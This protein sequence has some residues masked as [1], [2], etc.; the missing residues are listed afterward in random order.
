[1]IV[2]PLKTQKVTPNSIPIEGLLDSA[3]QSLEQE[4]IVVISAKI[5]ALCEGHVYEM[6]G[7]EKEQLVAAEADYYLPSSY[8]QYGFCISVKNNTL[9][10]SAG[11]DESNGNGFFVP[12]PKNPQESANTI[13][14]YLCEKFKIKNL[15]IVICDSHVLPLRWGTVGTSIAHSGF[16]ALRNYIGKPDVFGRP[17]KVTRSNIAE[18]IAAAAV[19]T[20]GEGDEQTPIAQVRDIPFVQFQDRNPTQEEI[21]MLAISMEEDIFA[22]LLTSVPWQRKK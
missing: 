7:N 21:D 17:L 4:S 5:V 14:S 18:G 13:R 1:M 8:N 6:S 22:P 15:G 12:W 9:I 10:A 3:I 16:V 2:T 11:I 19:L 20:M